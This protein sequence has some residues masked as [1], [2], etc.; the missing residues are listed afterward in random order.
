MRVGE[1]IGREEGEGGG[2]GCDGV[3]DGFALYV[4]QRRFVVIAGMGFCT[5]VF[6][7]GWY[8]ICVLSNAAAAASMRRWL[9]MSFDDGI[10]FL[11]GDEL[12]FLTKR[13]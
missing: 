7:K 2:A 8:S 3:E 13:L 6:L 4:C 1:D 12:V 10:I 5:M 11:D 9:W